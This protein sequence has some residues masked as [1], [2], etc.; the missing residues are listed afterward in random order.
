METHYC[1]LNILFSGTIFHH[2][3]FSEL[4]F[5]LWSDTLGELTAPQLQSQ[6]DEAAQRLFILVCFSLRIN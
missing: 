3:K 5:M 6:F 4:N 2:L 1:R